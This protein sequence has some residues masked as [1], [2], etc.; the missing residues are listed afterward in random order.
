MLIALSL[1]YHVYSCDYSWESGSRNIFYPEWPNQV[2]WEK[3]SEYKIKI[4]IMTNEIGD[5]QLLVYSCNKKYLVYSFHI[6]TTQAINHGDLEGGTSC[7]W[8]Q[9]IL[10]KYS[11]SGAKYHGLAALY[12][13]RDVYVV[14]QYPSRHASTPKMCHY[15]ANG[16][17]N[18]G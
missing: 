10:W 2:L 9:Q 17:S 4:K 5:R 1:P 18:T 6:K 3:I 13:P 16:L 12:E 11:N 7:H 14:W 8:L 15:F